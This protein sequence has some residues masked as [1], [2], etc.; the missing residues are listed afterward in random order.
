MC[1]ISHYRTQLVYR[2]V[3]VFTVNSEMAGSERSN[4]SP[5]FPEQ[6]TRTPVLRRTNF[7]L[8]IGRRIGHVSPRSKISR[9]DRWRNPETPRSRGSAAAGGHV[10]SAGREITGTRPCTIQFAWASL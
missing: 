9:T 8:L 6:T 1:D 4:R 5:S 2:W 3:N 10:N 7:T